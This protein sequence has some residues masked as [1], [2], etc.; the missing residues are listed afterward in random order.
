MRLGELPVPE[1]PVPGTGVRG[2]RPF[3]PALEL[4]A[5]HRCFGHRCFGSGTGVFASLLLLADGGGSARLARFV[6]R[7]PVPGTAVD[8]W[9]E[10]R[11]W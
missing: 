10:A 6:V 9:R 1:L 2:G 8:L 7:N 3:T 11:G 4:G 5:W